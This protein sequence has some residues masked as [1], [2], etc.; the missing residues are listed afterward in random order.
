MLTNNSLRRLAYFS[1][2]FLIVG[3]Q[4]PLTANV[5]PCPVVNSPLQIEP[6]AAVSLVFGSSA[7]QTA[8]DSMVTRLNTE[9]DISDI[10]LIDLGAGSAIRSLQAKGGKPTAEDVSAL[11]SYLSGDVVPMIQQYP[12]CD[13]RVT[14]TGK[15]LI[16]IETVTMKTAGAHRL[17]QVTVANTGSAGAQCHVFIK[18]FLGDTE[19][20]T[21]TIDFRLA[22]G[23]RRGLSIHNVSLP[24]SETES[25]RRKISI[26]VA[27]WYS[28]E[29]AG[30]RVFHI[31][32]W[33][34]D[35]ARQVF[36]M[37]HSK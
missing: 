3:C 16:G 22:P 26:V 33:Q 18:Q 15:P 14:M 32:T 28:R 10:S 25:D 24:I 36:V 21:G 6:S 17:P 4:K 37:V 2:Y 5:A 20:S 9:S 11:K 1:V 35:P 23:Q 34:Y 27:I 12:T 31:E 29:F 8:L 7:I 30:T 19:H 13:F